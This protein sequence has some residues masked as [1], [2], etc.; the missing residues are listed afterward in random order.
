MTL[1][2][3]VR[4]ARG[5][6]GR[7]LLGAGRMTPD[8]ADAFDAVDRALFLPGVM[9]P[10]DMRTRTSTG[11]DKDADPDAWYRHADA[12]VAI[13]TQW[14]DGHHQGLAPGRVPTSSASMPS[15]VMAMLRDLDVR[16]G[17]RV[18][19]IGTGSGWNAALLAHRL[20]DDRVTTV[21]V[22]PVVAA[23]ARAALAR[24]GRHPRVVTG[25]GLLGFPPTAPY[26]RVIATMGLRRIP[27][28]WVRQT[29]P[30]GVIL[31]PWGTGYSHADALVRLVVADDGASASGRF[32]G[33]AEFMKARAHRLARPPHQAY[34]PEGFPG[35]A[36]ASTTRLT[37]H[38]LGF[39]DRLDHPFAFVAGL[40][41]G[42]VAM[43]TDRR[44]DQRS[45]WL[46][47]LSDR[48]WAAVLFLDGAPRSTVHQ[49]GPR[50]LWAELEAAHR[51]WTDAGRPEVGRFGLT[52]TAT[53][54]HT[55]LDTPAQP[56]TEVAPLPSV[57]DPATTFA[58]SVTLPHGRRG[59]GQ[60]DLSAEEQL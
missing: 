12:N 27:Y 37:P 10:H 28:A 15:L 51:W 11:V 6:L 30:G 22:D 53:G 18:L 14:D 1:P 20:G 45:T 38:D 44:G 59:G 50:R 52:V 46:Y 34:L 19:E 16:A 41:L 58:D 8:W 60:R 21:E 13:T 39:E 56:L 55:W 57:A 36:D 26:H 47:G 5:E 40:L 24:A 54:E 3:Q 42:D 31:A 32:T 33:T 43:A 17:M 2:R 9:W 4:P 49:C 35:G 23:A 7:F 29:V 25:D 48:S